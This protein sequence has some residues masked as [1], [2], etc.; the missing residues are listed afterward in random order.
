MRTEILQ[1]AVWEK[2]NERKEERGEAR[3]KLS[4]TTKITAPYAI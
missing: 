1:A 4:Q 2:K 3:R